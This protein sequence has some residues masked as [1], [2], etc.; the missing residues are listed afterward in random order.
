MSLPHQMLE[1][2]TDFELKWQELSKQHE[3]LRQHHEETKEQLHTKITENETLQ[4][5]VKDLQTELAA[6]TKKPA[7]KPKLILNGNQDQV[8][9]KEREPDGREK[10]GRSP[11]DRFAAKYGSPTRPKE[12]NSPSTPTKPAPQPTV[13]NYSPKPLKNV[14]LSPMTEELLGI[15]VFD[16]P[17]YSPHSRSP[18]RKAASELSGTTKKKENPHG[19]DYRSTSVSLKKSPSTSPTPR[20]P[21]KD[22]Q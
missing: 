13:Y 19:N 20:P 9:G 11:V 18:V 4:Q 14:T 1:E 6:H 8:K 12:E 22:A 10:Y 5:S 2:K 15:N 3:A 7:E 16:E 21:T 17:V